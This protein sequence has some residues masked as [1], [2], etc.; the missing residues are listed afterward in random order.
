MSAVLTLVG[1]ALAVTAASGC[2][3]VAPEPTG[4][5]HVPAAGH[6][7]REPEPLV[8]QAPGREAL[9]STGPTARPKAA[10]PRRTD[11]SRPSPPGRPRATA[12]PKPRTR[13]GTPAAAP[14]RPAA[15]VPVPTTVAVPDVCGMAERYGAWRPGGHESR[16]CREAA[17]R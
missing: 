13:A 8:G 1:V 2:V 4:P 5:V 9:E 3:S 12:G 7:A 10:P 6:P 14:V 16:M 15:P 17:R 11:R